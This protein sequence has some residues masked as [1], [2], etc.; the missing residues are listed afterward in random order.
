MFQV[1][2]A[3]PP[4]FL[5]QAPR[6]SRDLVVVVGLD[7][8]DYFL[9]LAVRSLQGLVNRERPRIWVQPARPVMGG[10]GWLGRFEEMGLARTVREMSAEDFLESHKGFA[11]G[12]VVP[13]LM[14][15]TY[16]HHGMDGHHVAVM[17]AAAR[18]LIVAR[19]DLADSLGL[20]VKEDLT[21][22]FDGLG[23]SL[24]Y[25]YEH[26]LRAGQLSRTG[27]FFEND[28]NSHGILTTDYTVQHRL[29][30]FTWHT[31]TRLLPGCMARPEDLVEEETE[32][33]HKVLGYLPG[34]SPVLGSPGAGEGYVDEGHLVVTVSRYGKVFVP[35]A[36]AENL[37]VHCGFPKPESSTL[38]Q[39][40][41]GRP[42]YTEGKAYVAVHMSDG[43]N[44]NL[45]R[46]HWI[47][48]RDETYGG[49]WHKRGRIPIGW[50]MGPAV[51]ELLPGVARYYYTVEEGRPTPKDEIIMGF[52]G[53]GYIFPGEFGMALDEEEREAVWR[54]YLERTEAFLRYMDT[55]VVATQPHMVEGGVMGGEVFLRYSRGC[56]SLRG[57]FNGYNAVAQR[58]R[59][60]TSEYGG[61]PVFHSAVA[62]NRGMPGD[63]ILRRGIQ[64]MAGRERPAFIHLF[65][66]PMGSDLN[67]IADELQGLPQD[68]EIVM[69]S[70]MIEIYREYRAREKGP[71][72]GRDT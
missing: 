34:L 66:I 3:G 68:Y 72:G 5:P 11:A 15:Y 25:A 32:V 41:V 2:R 9:N 61:L 21:D 63:G 12:A 49:A 6:T 22:A 43:D 59:S 1:D 53:L 57:V 16:A 70:A 26:L 27:A 48:R 69:P 51:F 62:M 54:E 20:D 23:E 56:P 10:R 31:K 42:A 8:N 19:G 37:S 45:A 17:V 40:R 33:I 13:P 65:V 35:C 52:C 28:S 55:A 30:Q 47:S 71:E 4:W 67:Y 24:D 44:T 36:G 46:S 38:K 60:L 39:R 64:K 7:E 14:D 18:D 58:Y 29:F 50:S